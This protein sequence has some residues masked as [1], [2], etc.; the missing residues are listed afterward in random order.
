ME[1]HLQS[2]IANPEVTFP[3]TLNA[4][5]TQNIPELNGKEDHVRSQ[6]CWMGLDS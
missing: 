1:G 3:K 2:T 6:N 5:L 4:L